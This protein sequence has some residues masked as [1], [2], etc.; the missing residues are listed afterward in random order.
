MY[1]HGGGFVIHGDHSHDGF[2]RALATGTGHVVVSV[3]YRLAPEHPFP[4]AVDD[5]EA[6]ACYVA[7]HASQFGIDPEKLSVAGDSAGA[8]LAAVTARLTRTGGAALATQ[9][10]IVPH[11]LYPPQADTVSRRQFDDG[12]YLTTELLAWFADQYVPDPQDRSDP[13]A[14]PA[15]A[16][17]LTGLPP[18]L[19]VTAGLDPL[20]DKGEQYAQAMATA[21]VPVRQRRLEGAFHLLWLATKTNPAV[22]ANLIGLVAEHLNNPQQQRQGRT[23]T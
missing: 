15:L 12:P 9:V 1:F 5:A 17:D 21:G 11:T 3:D 18:A 20:R 2:L 10:L 13:R 4:A 23:S 22:Q 19:V 7:A 8:T 14:A 16:P 6:A